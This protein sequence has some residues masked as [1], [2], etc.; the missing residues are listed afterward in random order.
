MTASTSARDGWPSA[1]TVSANDT[2]TFDGCDLAELARERGTPL[3]AISRATIEES[4]RRVA[5]AVGRRY[6]RSEIA[7]SIKANNTMAVIRLLHSLGAKIDA[8]AEHEFQLALLC[9]VPP[10][11]VILNGNGKSEAALHAAARLGARQV[12]VDSL[13]EVR[14]LSAIATELGTTVRCVVRVQ[15]GYER[16]LTLDPSFE[17]TL[18]VSEGKFGANVTTGQALETI[19][20]VVRAPGLELCGLHHHVGFSGYMG[21]FSAERE[22]M[23]H[24]ECTREICE[25]ANDVKRRFG[26][27][28]DRL[29]LGGGLR[30]GGDVLLSTPGDAADVAF[31]ALP[32]PDDYV[33][34][35]FDTLE[36]TLDLAEAPL[37]QFELGG[38][39]VGSAVV[40][41]TEVAE[42]KDV[43]L[44]P[45]RR[46]V[47]VDGSSMMFVSRAM[48]RLGYPVVPVAAPL[49]AA[50]AEWPVDVVGQTCVYD[51]VAEQ[52]R[53]PRL[54]RGDLLAVLHQG[55]YCETESTQF[56]AF[57][58]PE[59]VLLD[60][61]RASVVRRRE[62]F[63]DI[64]ARDLVPTELWAVR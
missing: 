49:A 37:V 14:R 56:N 12:N 43:P 57:P 5:D 24:R 29:D 40:L 22:V 25:L 9:G 16:L 19:E 33:T 10:S 13:D 1:L 32:A 2:L 50:D 41:L 4:Y 11:D 46:F 26:V 36:E 62:S 64:H 58:R 54:E 63:A 17:P 53:L 15:L 8:S 7:Y 44:S 47:V 42:V 52:I 61:G 6:P 45:P 28:I 55:A 27:E 51:S 31:H 30:L 3:W 59:V 18:F 23:H 35:I 21:D 38:H 60:R 39:L 20:A 34:A 48:M